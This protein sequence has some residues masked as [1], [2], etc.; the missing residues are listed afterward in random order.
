MTKPVNPDIDDNG[1]IENLHA[2]F[3]ADPY[4]PR[5]QAQRIAAYLAYLETTSAVEVAQL[6]R[7]IISD[8]P[9]EQARRSF[10]ASVAGGWPGLEQM[11]L[12]AVQGFDDWE[13]KVA[14]G[15]ALGLVPVSGEPYFPL[16]HVRVVRAHLG[17]WLTFAT[18]QAHIAA[19]LRRLFLFPRDFTEEMPAGAMLSGSTLIPSAR[20]MS[21]YSLSRETLLC[22]FPREHR[23]VGLSWVKALRLVRSGHGDE[24]LCDYL[25]SVE[26]TGLMGQ[27]RLV[28]CVSAKS[29]GAELCRLE[30]SCDD[31]SPQIAPDLPG[32]G[33]FLV[34]VGSDGP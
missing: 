7:R 26:R 9:S 3:T 4:Q 1:V 6:A 32:D 10:G 20:L 30:F 14:T 18:E 19:A 17:D 29:D 31:A 15:R 8:S 27:A 16:P 11:L 34:G 23:D 24:G 28:V 33:Q 22:E 2:A 25:V 13:K 12:Q 5:M 21:P